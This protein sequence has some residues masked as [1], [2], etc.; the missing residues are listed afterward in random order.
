LIF[1][2]RLRDAFKI[3]KSAIA[4]L[5]REGGVKRASFYLTEGGREGLED[6]R[7]DLTLTSEKLF[8]KNFFG[9]NFMKFH[10]F[11][12]LSFSS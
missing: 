6:E 11:F 10:E 5:G 1:C 4:D 8:Q 7:A 2:K 3:S 9:R 12:L